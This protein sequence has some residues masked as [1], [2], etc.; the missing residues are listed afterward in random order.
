MTS[1][2]ATQAA[3]DAK[4]HPAIAWTARLGFAGYGLV[5]LLIAWLTV[6][7]AFGRPDESVSGQGA[8]AQLSQQPLGG[9][10]LWIV[11]G[12]FAALVVWELCQTIGGHRDQHG[13]KRVGGRA[14]SA[15]RAVVF[16]ALGFTAARIAVNGAGSSGSSSSREE[17]FTAKVLDLPYGP[18]LVG[19]IG[20]GLVVYGICSI[21]GGFT[22]FWRKQIDVDGRTG[23]AGKVISTLARTGYVARGIAFGIV[24]GLVVWAAAT[25][26]PKKSGGLDEA[27]TTLRDAPAGPYLLLAVAIG[28]ACFGV[29]N[30]AKVWFLRDV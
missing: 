10:L 6:Q 4:D 12:G 21:I 14:A 30:M 3:D 13:L 23:T 5:Y 20:V 24:G 28:L 11:A 27:L 16:G 22:D 8:L 2:V 7:L 17:G 19:A 18:F 26:D 25:H 15:G 29:F 1:R 9:V